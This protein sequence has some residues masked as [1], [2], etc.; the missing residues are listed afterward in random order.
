MKKKIARM[1]LKKKI[2]KPTVKKQKK[3][4]SVSNSV[5]VFSYTKP[6]FF[7]SA[8]S[9]AASAP[10]KILWVG[11]YSVLEKGSSSLVTA[12]DKRVFATATEYG[13]IVL[14]SPQ[15]EFQVAAKFDE[16]SCKLVLEREV[17]AA[18]FVA[19]AAEVSLAYLSV[20][21]I[22]LKKFFLET[23][24]DEA[25]G[26][27]GGKSGLGSSAAACAAVVAC[28]LSFHAFHA[29]Q[30]LVNNLSQI[31]HSL[32]QGKVGSGFDV[33]AACFGSCAYS[34]YSPEL[35]SSLGSSPSSKQIAALA[36]S[37]WDYSVEKIA[38]PSE[39]RIVF[40]N[41]EGSSA[42]TTEMVRKAMEW[43]KAHPTHY[44]SLVQELDDANQ[45]AIA[46]L[47]K[48]DWTG[49]QNFF[50]L[51]RVLTKKL[52]RLA[53]AQIEPPEL[54]ELVEESGRNG[55]FA[56]K[57]PGAGGGDAIAALCL[58]ESGEKK[59]KQFWSN[60]SRVK[61][62]LVELAASSEG[63]QVGAQTV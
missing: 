22:P 50:I 31:A 44:Y 17:P 49:F 9:V 57:L 26:M 1:A 55:A 48:R 10:G 21:K 42:S 38:L 11:G 53:G 4:S 36:D 20:K 47:K 58:S 13:Q 52:G 63:V 34:R 61:L 24:G 35:V 32:A 27:G 62:R 59:L 46:S 14:S 28:V 37:E 30:K 25:F 43:K 45:K 33:A 2:S 3:P 6:R 51:G 7:P 40:A 54:S 18:R 39:L 41:I 12:V 29:S 19:K 60:Y 15:Y 56:C 8:R 23:R 16:K 5:P